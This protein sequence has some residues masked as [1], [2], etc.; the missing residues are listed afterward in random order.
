[1]PQATDRTLD[2]HTNITGNA[3]VTLGG[4]GDVVGSFNRVE[5]LFFAANLNWKF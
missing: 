2:L 1:M 4:R 5:I 3:P